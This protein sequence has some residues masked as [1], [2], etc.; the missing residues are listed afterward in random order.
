M[1]HC[2]FGNIF[3]KKSE[4]FLK[5]IY[6]NF[7]K[8]IKVEKVYCFADVIKN[9]GLTADECQRLEKGDPGVRTNTYRGLNLEQRDKE[10]FYLFKS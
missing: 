2:D 5:S 8:Y 10:L 9:G 1:A 4:V 6:I 3:S 7:H